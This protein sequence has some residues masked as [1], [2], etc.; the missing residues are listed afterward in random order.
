MFCML[1]V[2]AQLCVIICTNALKNKNKKPAPNP[3]MESINRKWMAG[4]T[5]ETNLQNQ[6]QFSA[7]TL[8]F[9]G[10][11]ENLGSVKSCCSEQKYIQPF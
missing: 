2:E 3:V 8:L 11:A 1:P 6:S 9:S 5:E 4:R 7:V 10:S